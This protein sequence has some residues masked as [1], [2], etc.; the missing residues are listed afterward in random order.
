MRRAPGHAGPN[1]MA[2]AL[3]HGLVN[4]PFTHAWQ[5]W[6]HVAAVHGSYS[7]TLAS[8]ATAGDTTISLTAEPTLNDY[9][10]L[11]SFS[12]TLSSSA[13]QGATSVSIAAAPPVGLVLVFGSITGSYGGDSTVTAVTG[14][15]PYTVTISPALA[16]SQTSGA[17][18]AGLTPSYRVTGITGSGPYAATVTQ[19][20]SSWPSG[21]AVTALSTADVFLDQSAGLDRNSDGTP[22]T[23]NG[24]AVHLTPG[25]RY[26][27]GLSLS[28]G[29]YVL[30]GRDVV[31]NGH[32]SSRIILGTV[33]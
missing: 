8:P 31:S 14:S 25:I 30:L 1:A 4:D 29:D 21:E 2:Q 5:Q 33:A 15:G 13:A 3:R 27:S 12:S 32:G 17:A 28:V 26:L 6:G 19:L 20:Q 23:K 10:I 16:Y 24:I 22:V 11:G 9:L 18:V 7:S